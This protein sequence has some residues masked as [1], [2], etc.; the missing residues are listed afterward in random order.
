M[1]VL[2]L[3]EDRAR[4]QF[5]KWNT[6]KHI[7][8]NLKTDKNNNKKPKKVYNDAGLWG[9][10]I[11]SKERYDGSSDGP[12]KFAIV[13]TIKEVNG[14]NRIHDFIRGSIAREWI[15]NEI[16]INERIIINNKSEDEIDW[17]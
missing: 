7:Y 4:R 2:E 11:N 9:I 16:D 6:V 8:E 10:N 5:D 3:L 15:V 14:K 13:I 1:I 12:T 17:E